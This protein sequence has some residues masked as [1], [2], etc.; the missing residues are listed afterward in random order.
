M[1]IYFWAWVLPLSV[2]NIPNET[3]LE[4]TNFSFASRCQLEIASW[5][6]IGAGVHFS[7]SAS[8]TLV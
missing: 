4:K 3:H 5:L 2:G 6:E 1:V 8:G 7:L